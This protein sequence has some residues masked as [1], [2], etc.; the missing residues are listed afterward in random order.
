MRENSYNVRMKF[1]KTP[2]EKKI[3]QM[4]EGQEDARRHNGGTGA[5]ADKAVE[6]SA[7]DDPDYVKS[8]DKAIA[9]IPRTSWLRSL[10]RY[11][12]SMA[13]GLFTMAFGAIVAPGS[14]ALLIGGLLVGAVCAAAIGVY[15]NYQVNKISEPVRIER[16]EQHSIAASKMYGHHIAKAYD[17]MKQTD[18]K[19]SVEINPAIEQDNQPDKNWLQA[20]QAEHLNRNLSTVQTR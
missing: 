4:P 19:Q 18:Q 11:A 8:R 6:R 14:S 7:F 16:Q 2:N 10:D 17:T 9:I 20:M 15:S 1:P 13:M 5:Y 3:L 12:G